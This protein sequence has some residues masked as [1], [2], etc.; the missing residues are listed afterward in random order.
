MVNNST[1]ECP[2]SVKAY[3]VQSVRSWLESKS[4]SVPLTVKGALSL[5]SAARH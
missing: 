5:Y 4:V 2:S 1:E 3:L